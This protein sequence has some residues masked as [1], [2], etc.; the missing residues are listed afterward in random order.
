MKFVRKQ[1]NKESFNKNS[2]DVSEIM[3]TPTRFIN[4]ENA[5]QPWKKQ[6]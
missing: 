3:K 2:D 6:N 4:S 1:L 5:S